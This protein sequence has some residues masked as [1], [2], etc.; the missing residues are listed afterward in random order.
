MV[1]VTNDLKYNFNINLYHLKFVVELFSRSQDCKMQSFEQHELPAPF[2]PLS[3][4]IL[5]LHLSWF[6]EAVS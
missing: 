2:E 1:Q 3:L 4:T 6:F 5:S